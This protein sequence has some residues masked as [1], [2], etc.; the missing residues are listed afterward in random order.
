MET[1]TL[2]HSQNLR[3]IRFFLAWK[4]HLEVALFLLVDQAVLVERA[5]RIHSAYRLPV[6]ISASLETR[7]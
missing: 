7:R 2:T 6:R 1:S 3:V 5:H 4:A